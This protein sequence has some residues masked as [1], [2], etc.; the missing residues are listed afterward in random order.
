MLV[1]VLV[2]VHLRKG[3]TFADTAAGFGVLVATAWRYVEEI[4]ALLLRVPQLRA[5]LRKA[6]AS[7]RTASGH[8]DERD[9]I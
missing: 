8:G 5:A 3:E 4:V 6:P 1:L 2:L 9:I 7:E